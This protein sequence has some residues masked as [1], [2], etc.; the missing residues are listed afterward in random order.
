MD[1]DRD[2]LPWIFGGLSMATV[3]MAITLG[4]TYGTA[5][6]NLQASRQVAPHA[7]PDAEAPTARA[8]AQTQA[9]PQTLAAAQ[10]LPAAPIQTAAP[11]PE[12][13]SQIWECAINGQKTFTDNPCGDKSSLHEIGPINRMDPTPILPHARSFVPESSYQPEYS[14]PG[15]QID[16]YAGEQQFANNA[17]NSYPVFIGIP[18]HERGRPDH[19]HRPHGHDRGPQPR[20]N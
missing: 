11:P 13:S 1:K 10:T 2:L 14:Y 19:G 6:R 12:A 7:L 3:A 20:K 8:T 18:F 15:E 17:N 4:S 5:P 9:A 16:S